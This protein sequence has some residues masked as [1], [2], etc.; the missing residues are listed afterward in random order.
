MQWLLQPRFLGDQNWANLF[1][2]AGYFVAGYIVVADPRFV[3]A[4]RRD[5]WVMLAGALGAFVILGA[6]YA[7]GFLEAWSADPGRAEYYLFFAIV[8]LDSWCWTMTM[9][10]VGVRFMDRPSRWVSYGQEAVLPFYVI[11]QPV[12]LALAF[13]VVQWSTGIAA[14]W[15]AIA[16]PAFVISVAVYDLLIRRVGVV[17]MLFGLKPA[18]PR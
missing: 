11:H 10:Y 9:L 3:K 12:I 1:W 17:R 15:I 5:R 4:L 7:A 13:F 6:I 14:K 2:M 18:A 16:V 8:C